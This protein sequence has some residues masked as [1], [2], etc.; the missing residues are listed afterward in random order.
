M[1]HY[2]LPVL[3]S[4]V[5]VLPALAQD[6]DPHETELREK[7]IIVS[8]PGKARSTDELVG[9]AEIIDRDE[10]LETL[11]GTLGDTLAQKP[12][13]STSYF[14][15]G[16][17]R[18][19]IRG[20]GA[21][22][23]LVLTNGIGVI[24]AS[25]AS[26]DHQVAADALD[27]TRIEVVRGPAALAYGGQAIGG[28]VNVIDGLIVEKQP[29]EGSIDLFAATTSVDEGTQLAGRAQESAG[30]FVFTLQASAR[31]SDNIDIPGSAVSDVLR[32]Q[33]ISGGGTVDAGPNDTLENSFVQTRSLSGG[34]SWIGDNAFV[35]ADVRNQ[36][37]QYGLPGEVGP[38]IDLNQTRYDV[39]GGYHFHGDFLDR[40]T[41]SLASAD[42]KHTEF[43]GPGQPGTKFLTDG[44]EGR[45]EIGHNEVAG[46][47]GTFGIQALSKTLKALGDESFITATDTNN[48]GAFLY[49]ARDFDNAVGVEGG[50]RFDSVSVDNVTLGK[51]DFDT[52]SASLAVHKHFDNGVFLGAETS[53]VERAPTDVELFANGP[54][55]ATQQFELGNANIGTEAGLNLELALRWTGDN[56]SIGT[57]IFYNDFSD[58]IFL[59]PTGQQQDGLNEF[60]FTQEDAQFTGA[61]IYSDWDLGT[62]IGADWKLNAGLDLVSA[63][64]SSG[65]NLPFIPPVTFK[66]GI[67]AER[68]PWSGGLK[69]VIA[70]S[71][72]DTAPNE[73]PTDGYAVFDARFAADL[74]NWGIGKEGT[75]AF[76]EVRNLTDEEVRISSS[77]LKD[78]APMAGRNLRF[79][80]KL[81]Y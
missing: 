66:G 19:I 79:G 74:S 50:L 80:V 75:Q 37:A 71:Q 32:Q 6:I 81:S 43:E 69:T 67:T 4:S 18:P 8:V 29:G 55:L 61:E 25:S 56:A 22:R 51:H 45:F 65:A 7:T 39:R 73:L 63:E 15:P 12:G 14:G 38:F 53:Y 60:A 76:V 54:H 5:S 72:D 23:V 11:T 78:I 62:Y 28:V 64:L 41:L 13:I 17:S 68:G 58:F 59:S 24:D 49:E 27:A 48:L 30:P 47:E 9:N 46:F 2:I 35:G 42:Y 16:A 77:P 3:L 52:V 57:N 44:T 31:D 40:A 33:I 70:A 34:V 26:P 1:K 36:T 21:E 20:L 10:L